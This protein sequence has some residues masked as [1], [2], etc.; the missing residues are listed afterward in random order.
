[1]QSDQ[2]TYVPGVVKMAVAANLELLERAAVDAVLASTDAAWETWC[3]EVNQARAVLFATATPLYER[4][5]VAVSARARA[6][7]LTSLHRLIEVFLTLVVVLAATVKNRMSFNAAAR[8]FSNAH[9]AYPRDVVLAQWVF[10]A[11]IGNKTEPLVRR[12]GS[13][14]GD[15]F[16]AMLR[17]TT[18]STV[19][20]LTGMVA[21][22]RDLPVGNEWF[23]ASVSDAAASSAAAAAAPVT[24]SRLTSS[25]DA[26][27]HR[28]PKPLAIKGTRSPAASSLAESDPIFWNPQ[29]YAVSSAKSARAATPAPARYVD[30]TD[31]LAKALAASAE[32]HLAKVNA[33]Q[34]E[35]Q[36]N[37]ARSTKRVAFA[38]RDDD[39]DDDEAV[40]A[41][42]DAPGADEDE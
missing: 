21:Q 23:P 4:I 11:A 19:E 18:T 2:F 30:D 10:A 29:M 35:I 13:V 33:Q 6:L 17:A 5:L 1:M 36:R 42:C 22:F 31:A 14:T 7:N 20:Q 8:A 26:Y 38:A 3:S 39:D 41:A 16:A 32:E 34:A 37:Y 40:L 25:S 28:A 27:V 9:H 12:T 15:E 24:T